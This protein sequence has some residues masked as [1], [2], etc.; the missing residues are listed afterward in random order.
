[1]W[2]ERSF[3]AYRSRRHK[4]RDPRLPC[5][6]PCRPAALP[7]CRHETIEAGDPQPSAPGTHFGLRLSLVSLVRNKPL[8]MISN[9]SRALPI[10]SLVARLAGFI[11]APLIG[12]PPDPSAQEMEASSANTLRVSVC[13]ASPRTPFPQRVQ[14]CTSFPA[15]NRFA[16]PCTTSLAGAL[17]CRS[18]PG[19][20]QDGTGTRLTFRS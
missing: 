19:S 20:R 14:S 3:A 17:L 4:P 18:T 7:P 15:H 16:L 10:M 6:I 8:A 11:S 12:S 1:M 13:R 9:G 2:R 5:G